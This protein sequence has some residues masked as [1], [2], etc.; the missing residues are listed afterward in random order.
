MMVYDGLGEVFMLR[1]G[2][3]AHKGYNGG[4]EMKR[5][6]KGYVTSKWMV[7]FR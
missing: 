4:Y 6:V 1:E 2:N 5:C 3:H 7:G